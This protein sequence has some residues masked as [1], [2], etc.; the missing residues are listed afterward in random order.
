MGVKIGFELECVDWERAQRVMSL[1]LALLDGSM[2]SGDKTKLKFQRKVSLGRRTA[3][4]KDTF[5]WCFGEPRPELSEIGFSLV[6][7]PLDALLLA[8]SRSSTIGSDA[9]RAAPQPADAATEIGQTAADNDR[10]APWERLLRE[11]RSE[12]CDGDEG[13]EDE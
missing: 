6:E 3:E 9:E 2:G 13:A 11:E 1:V 8:G 7:L 4:K 12:E 5:A 10:L